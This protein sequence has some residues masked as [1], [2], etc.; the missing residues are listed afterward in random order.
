MKEYDLLIIGSGPAGLTAGL[1]AGR[2]RLKTLIVG[3]LTGGLMTLAHKVCNFPSEKEISGMDLTEKMK[4][5]VL[6]LGVEIRQ[7][8]VESLKKGGNLFQVGTESGQKFLAKTL[9]L[10]CGTRHRRLN[11]PDEEKFLGR[12]VS[13][14]STCD[15]PLY[16]DKIVGVVGG[17]N[18]AA[19]AV[20]YLSEIAK[21]VFL[22][23]RKSK[24][25]ADP[26]WVENLE[27]KNNVEA[28]FNTNVIKLLGEDR[29][30]K[31]KLDAKHRESEFLSVDGL[32]LEIGTVPSGALS[33]QLKVETNEKGYIKV[34][35]GG[36]T[37]VK[38]VWAAGDITTGSDGFMQII[39]ACAEGAI[40]AQSIYKH[41]SGKGA[42]VRTKGG[43][44]SE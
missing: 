28:I 4:E 35:S 26:I 1:Y 21:K 22:I 5:Q 14:C 6:G 17:S 13:Y 15:G 8:E 38:G 34:D 32:F 11:L 10:A 36:G 18:A 25:R 19:T 37:N 42:A 3:V 16:R 12:G 23:Y 39:T 20:L 44:F 43:E 33:R 2:F 7:D 41:L 40:A 27:K 24:L 31:I 9:L 29:L 30:R